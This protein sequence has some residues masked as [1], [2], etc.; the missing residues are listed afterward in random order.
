M[1]NAD[2]IILNFFA[3]KRASSV[4]EQEND[5]VRFSRRI[6]HRALYLQLLNVLDRLSYED[7]ITLLQRADS[8]AKV[9]PDSRVQEESVSPIGVYEHVLVAARDYRKRIIRIIHYKHLNLAR[10]QVDITSGKC[11]FLTSEAYLI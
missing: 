7:K 11:K 6:A 3:L 1:P 4:R 2:Q 10:G 5:S 9:L 8:L